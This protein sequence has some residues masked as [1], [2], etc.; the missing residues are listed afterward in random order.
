MHKWMRQRRANGTVSEGSCN[1]M[2]K[3]NSKA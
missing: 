2:I 3:V 1:T